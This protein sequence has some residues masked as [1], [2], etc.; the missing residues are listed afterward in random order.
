MLHERAEAL[1]KKE[2]L[3]WWTQ[4]SQAV[5]DEARRKSNKGRKKAMYVMLFGLRL[6]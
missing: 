6:I 3:D 5:A 2:A 4:R 1:E